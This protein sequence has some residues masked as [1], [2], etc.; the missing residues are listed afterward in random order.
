MFTFNVN[1]PMSDTLQRV[2]YIQS[3]T[4]DVPNCVIDIWSKKMPHSPRR[5]TFTTVLHEH[6]RIPL[7]RTAD[8]LLHTNLEIRIM[9]NLQS[10][11]LRRFICWQQGNHIFIAP[12][13][14][15]ERNIDQLGFD[16]QSTKRQLATTCDIPLTLRLRQVGT[17]YFVCTEKVS[18]PIEY[19]Y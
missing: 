5:Y 8:E 16:L 12:P 18:I 13:N 2:G 10:E 1:I 7:V 19:L 17:E 15:K 14:D 4:N 9:N 6:L 3:I 11:C